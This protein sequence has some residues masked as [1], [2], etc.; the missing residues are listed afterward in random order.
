MAR[1]HEEKPCALSSRA[2]NLSDV[3]DSVESPREELAGPARFEQVSHEHIG[4]HVG[5]VNSE[6]LNRRFLNE[7]LGLRVSAEARKDE[8]VVPVDTCRLSGLVSLDVRHWPVS[9]AVIS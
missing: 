7:C 3:K 4:I 5:K 8:Y 6:T 9:R 2:G 1:F